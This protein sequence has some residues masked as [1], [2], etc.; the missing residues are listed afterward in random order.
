MP[1]SVLE[2]DVL[3]ARVGGYRP[4]DLDALCTAGEVVWVGAGPLGAT[5]GRV[6]LLFRD[7]AGLLVAPGPMALLPPGDAVASTGTGTD[8][9]AI[10]TAA[11]GEAAAGAVT[12]RVARPGTAGPTA[13]GKASGRTGADA[14]V[15]AAVDRSAEPDPT[16]SPLHQ[17]LRAHLT[18]RG[19]SFWPELVAAA[20]AA[21]A[22]Y[23]D[24]SVLDALWDL[25]WAGEV[26]NDSLAPLRAMV[27]GKAPQERR[28]TGRSSAS[29][30]R[31]S[32]QPRPA[33]PAG[34][35]ATRAARCGG[36]VVAGRAAAPAPTSAHRGGPRPGHAAARTTRRAHP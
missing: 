31:P 33:E 22:A 13:G 10:G 36:S 34:A 17:V 12:G 9:G 11:A 1:A 29:P 6:R 5:D 26:T 18:Q 21:G 2:A 27:A 24:G 3:P 4:A 28:V 30:R 20:S 23:D 32:T 19:A 7:Q 15:P 25:V 14:K 35:V 16:S 8:D